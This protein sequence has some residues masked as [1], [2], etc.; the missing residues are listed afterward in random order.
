MNKTDWKPIADFPGYEVSDDGRVRRGGLVKKPRVDRKGYLLVTLWRD[1]KPHTRQISR[2]VAQAFIGPR[3]DGQVVRH[4]NGDKADNAKGNLVYGTPTENEHDKRA[5]GTAP[6]G[7]NR[8]CRH[9]AGCARGGDRLPHRQN[10]GSILMTKSIATGAAFKRAG[11]GQAMTESEAFKTWAEDYFAG[12]Q[13][14]IACLAW[15]AATE[16]ERERCAEVCD[17]ICDAHWAIF[18]GLPPHTAHPARG[19]TYSQGVSEGAGSC[20]DAIRRGE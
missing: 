18:K 11:G 5:H 16:A 8:A 13:R 15:L 19:Y 4:C 20:S 14:E 9:R 10:H 3:P 7:E 12:P 2:L 1:H 17:E 6:I